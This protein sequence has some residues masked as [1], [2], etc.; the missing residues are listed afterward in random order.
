MSEPS[1]PSL[2][3]WQDF[4]EHR[5]SALSLLIANAF[6]LVGVLFW[7]WS[8]FAVV[9]VY[10]AENVVIGLINVLKMICCNSSANDAEDLPLQH[11]AKFF[12]VPFFTVHYGIFCAVH[13]V[14]VFALLGGDGG[15]LGMPLGNWGG[16][17]SMLRETGALWGIVA[18]AG[19]HLF[20]FFKNYLWGGEYQRVTL[21]QLMSSPYG[22]VVVLH[23]AILFG[24]F[25]TVALGS[26]IWVLVI[27]IVGKTALDL[28]LHLREHRLASDEQ[29]D[30]R[31][32]GQN[33]GNEGFGASAQ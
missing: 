4:S 7:G 5:S 22:R 11:A 12:F 1:V 18:L 25:A 27:L 24:A 21:P 8:T 20:S 10:W 3:S 9:V 26:P 17:M 32:D 14:F 19:S 30:D 13:G 15:E 16:R 31:Q 33:R 29:R 23:L 28:A 6:P 2:A